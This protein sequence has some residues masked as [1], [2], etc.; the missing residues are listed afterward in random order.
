MVRNNVAIV[1]CHIVRE[2]WDYEKQFTFLA[3]VTIARNGAV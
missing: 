2:I 3:I 1:K